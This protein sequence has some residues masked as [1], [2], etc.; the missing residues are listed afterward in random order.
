MNI[1]L[2]KRHRF[3]DWPN[4]DVPRV[5]IGVYL[6]W[7]GDEFVYCGMSGRDL[8]EVVEASK[9]KGLTTRLDSHAGGRLSGDQFCVYVAN[10][11][12]IPRLTQDQ[13][14]RFQKGDL[15]LD[16]LTKEYIRKRLEY[17]FA[18]VSTGKEARDLEA[19]YRNGTMLG[20]KPLLN[21]AKD[22]YRRKP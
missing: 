19:A 1:Q 2:S 18:V 6:I 13:L 5:A 17:Q 20:A 10:R 12:I 22:S 8:R 16:Q 14:P 4:A 7:D 21:P 11:F 9:K 15:T 3:A